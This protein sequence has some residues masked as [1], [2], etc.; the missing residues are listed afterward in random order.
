MLLTCWNPLQSSSVTGPTIYPCVGCI[1]VCWHL[2]H[3]VLPLCSPACTE[4][5]NRRAQM[6]MTPR[7]LATITSSRGLSAFGPIPAGLPQELA[8]AALR[9]Y[10]LLCSPLHEPQ[11]CLLPEMHKAFLPSSLPLG[12]A[13]C[14]AQVSGSS[15]RLELSSPE[16]VLPSEV[17]PL[18]LLFLC[19]LVYH[20][21][22]PPQPLRLWVPGE[23]SVVGLHQHS[24]PWV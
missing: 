3:P 7:L 5:Q 23:R 2:P 13:F 21:L 14:R 15:W 24:C 8:S 4:P 17:F 20:H 12:G 19:F 1:Q 10:L 11:T 18:R 22:S 16:V 9:T 6:W